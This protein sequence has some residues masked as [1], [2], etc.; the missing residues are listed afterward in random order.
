[1]TGA[2]SGV[3][4]AGDT[5]LPH[6]HPIAPVSWPSFTLFRCHRSGRL[7]GG[8]PFALLPDT[9]ATDGATLAIRRRHNLEDN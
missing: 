5:G 9:A 3:S 6:A 4:E 8:P 2:A 7:S 1:M